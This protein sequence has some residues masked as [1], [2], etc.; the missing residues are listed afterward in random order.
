MCRILNPTIHR[1]KNKF[2]S[3]VNYQL[4]KTQKVDNPASVITSG[5]GSPTENLSLFV[6]TYCK[7]V[8]DSIECRVK[9]A[10]HMLEKVNELNDTGKAESYFIGEL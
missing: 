2:H 10:A 9:D 5:C 6:E 4:I 1:I 8:L 3:G 7:V